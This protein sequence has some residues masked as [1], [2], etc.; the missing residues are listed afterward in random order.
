MTPSS[1]GRVTHKRVGDD[2]QRARIVEGKYGTSVGFISEATGKWG[3]LIVTPDGH[4]AVAYADKRVDAMREV[5][6]ELGISRRS[7]IGKDE[8]G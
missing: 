4:G 3:F 1:G 8:P 7:V 6:D 5:C 2:P